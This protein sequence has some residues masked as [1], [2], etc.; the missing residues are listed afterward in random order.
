MTHPLHGDTHLTAVHTLSKWILPVQRALRHL[1]F[2]SDRISVIL[3]PIYRL[4]N[5]YCYHPLLQGGGRGLPSSFPS[6]SASVT[7]AIQ[8]LW[9]INSSLCQNGRVDPKRLQ[10]QTAVQRYPQSVVWPGETLFSL[11]G[12][13]IRRN[14]RRSAADMAANTR[15]LPS[16]PFRIP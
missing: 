2:P 6:H 4:T 14:T 5:V 9:V 8:L 16:H 15:V 7:T 13:M 11:Q 3:H 10:L 12:R 1:S